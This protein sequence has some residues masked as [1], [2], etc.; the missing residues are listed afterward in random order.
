MF[1]DFLSRYCCCCFRLRS[2]KPRSA[3]AL[4]VGNSSYQS[5]A[6]L[7]N[8]KNDAALIA[9]TLRNAGFTLI[10]NHAQLDLDKAN[11]DKAI[12]NFGNAA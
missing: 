3:I 10:G 7:N 6:P 4:V 12:Q 8:P 5:V 9:E 11:F 2:A 1:Q